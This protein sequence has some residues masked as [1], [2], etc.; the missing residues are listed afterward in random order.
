[1]RILGLFEL[2]H[3]GNSHKLIVVANVFNSSLPIH[4]RFDLKGSTYKR[5]VGLDRRGTAGVVH[6]DI[7][8]MQMGRSLKLP[9]GMGQQL[10]RQIVLD[11]CFLERQGVIDYSLLIGVHRRKRRPEHTPRP[12][13]TP[14]SSKDNEEVDKWSKEH[15]AEL[16]SLFAEL[17]RTSAPQVK[18]GILDS[19][20]FADFVSFAHTSSTQGGGKTPNIQRRPSSEL[21]TELSADLDL[22]RMGAESSNW[23]PATDSEKDGGKARGKVGRGRVAAEREPSS[24]L[25]SEG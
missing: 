21:L 4:E 6:K 7:D 9:V 16:Q 24:F 12:A 18:G 20:S 14:A 25:D 2:H 15:S 5:T 13:T 19:L 8:F 22:S 17:K 11:A 10:R 1:M 3:D 23:M